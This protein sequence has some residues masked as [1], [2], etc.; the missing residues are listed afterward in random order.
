MSHDPNV[1][2]GGG[3]F[4]FDDEN[5]RGRGPGGSGRGPGGSGPSNN[6]QGRPKRSFGCGTIIGLVVLVMILGN[7]MNGCTDDS[8]GSGGGGGFFFLP[9][10]GGSSSSSGTNYGDGSGFRGGGPGT[11]K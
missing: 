2:M 8:N 6:G 11:G 4:N 5:G 7:I 1:S 10:F 9:F 3:S